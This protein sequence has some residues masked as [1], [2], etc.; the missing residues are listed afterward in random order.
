MPSEKTLVLHFKS[1]DEQLKWCSFIRERT[2]Q[3]NIKDFYRLEHPL[4]KGKFGEVRR[5]T[6]LGTGQRVAIKV[7]RKR[8]MK[9]IEIY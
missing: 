1:Q 7:I 8:D 6:H 2:R 9:P 3:K 4:G 5:G